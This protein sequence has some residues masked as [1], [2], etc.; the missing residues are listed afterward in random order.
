MSEQ[1]MWPEVR[2]A[3]DEKRYELVLVG[4][5][6]A[7]RIEDNKNALDE[8][9]YKLKHLNFLEVAKT[10]LAILPSQLGNMENMAK[11]VIQTP[12]FLVSI[13]SIVAG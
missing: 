10:Q 6:I 2:N 12:D 1:P 3:F 7:K 11:P 5:E 13:S 9:I 8:N 4:P